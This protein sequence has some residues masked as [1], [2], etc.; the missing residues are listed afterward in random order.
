MNPIGPSNSGLIPRINIFAGSIRGNPDS[1]DARADAADRSV[2][3][4][5]QRFSDKFLEADQSEKSG[6]R[7]SDGTYIPQ[8]HRAGKNTGKNA[9]DT[10]AGTGSLRRRSSS[11]DDNIGRLIDVE[12]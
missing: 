12:V 5:H 7:D 6:D 3:S 1:D 8:P 11:D 10:E 9:D 2:E 4:D